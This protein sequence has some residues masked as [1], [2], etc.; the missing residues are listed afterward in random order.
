MPDEHPIF[1]EIRSLLDGNGGG[2]ERLEQ[3]EHTLTAG[4]A[5]ALA[6]EAERWRIEQ[7]IAEVARMLAGPSAKLETKE[8]AGLAR[9]LADADEDLTEL[10]GLLSTLRTRAN[11]LRAA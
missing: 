1:A 9:R 3:I 4:Y 11:D 8:L 7:R 10:R 6:L 5:T 2:R